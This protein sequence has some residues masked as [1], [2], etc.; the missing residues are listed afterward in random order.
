MDGIL[1]VED[2]KRVRLGQAKEGFMKE[3]INVTLH[4]L[5][6]LDTD[7]G[8][9]LVVA[10]SGVV[11]NAKPSEKEVKVEDGVT[12]VATTFVTDPASEAALAELE[13]NNPGS[14]IVGSLV[15][16]QAY[17]GRVCGLVPAKGFERMPP[18][19]KRMNPKK[20]NIF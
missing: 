6:F 1:A 17:P 7:T 5:N 12:F 8:E 4:P 11:I 14:V 10:P 3:I 18:N 9:E 20:F 16:A 15:A 13:K 19:E 2:E